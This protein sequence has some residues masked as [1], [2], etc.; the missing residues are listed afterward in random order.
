MNCVLSIDEYRNDGYIQDCIES[1]LNKQLYYC[2]ENK[3]WC[4]DH[5]NE[6]T[7]TIVSLCNSIIFFYLSHPNL[8]NLIVALH[9]LCLCSRIKLIILRNLVINGQ[10]QLF[11]QEPNEINETI[12]GYHYMLTGCLA[13]RNYQRFNKYFRMLVE[14][15]TSRELQLS[16]YIFVWSDINTNFDKFS[17]S[18]LTI[19]EMINNVTKR[20]ENINTNCCPNQRIHLSHNV[21][22][23]RKQLARYDN[24]NSSCNRD[25][26]DKHYKPSLI[27][28]TVCSMLRKPKTFTTMKNIANFKQCHWKNC[29]KQN[30]ILK[31]C[32]QCKC[33]WYC[34]KK[35]QKMDW[36]L[37][38]QQC[39]QLPVKK[40]K[41]KFVR[42]CLY[43]YSVSNNRD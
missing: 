34:S 32:R 2:I 5:R 10:P 36:S 4:L 29:L 15:G 42:Q 1:I 26:R 9:R 39:K 30:K 43:D 16:R 28:S 6:M 20:F 19:E 31:L 24:D 7:T 25:D 8:N 13:M 40:D 23:K 18:Q 41:F 37:H 17:N 3:I 22:Y 21:F 35:C 38:K 33:V 27:G 14:Y 12:H 11:I